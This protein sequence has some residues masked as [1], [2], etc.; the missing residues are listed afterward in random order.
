MQIHVPAHIIYA[1]SLL[2]VFGV[3]TEGKNAVTEI[4]TQSLLSL[5]SLTELYRVA[6]ILYPY[7]MWLLYF[8]I[9]AYVD[10]EKTVP[11]ETEKYIWETIELISVDIEIYLKIL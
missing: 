9:H 1:I 3:A 6:D 4:K 11:D 7:K 8:F 10:I 5:G 2:H